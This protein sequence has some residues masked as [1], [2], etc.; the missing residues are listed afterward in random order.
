MG[1]FRQYGD[2]QKYKS[3]L[4]NGAM[5]AILL[6]LAVLTLFPIY[7]MVISSFGP[8]NEIGAASYTLFPKYVTLDSY[9]FF[10]GFSKSSFRWIVNS[11]IVAG[12]VTLSNVVFA[13]MA[14][15]AFAK[16]RFPGSKVLFFLL[17]FAMMVPYQVTQVPLYI[18]V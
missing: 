16:V 8:P 4:R 15:Y 10:F 2:D 1:L 12:V 14:G 5:A 18:L 17:L 7:Y 6:F 11:M 13:G 9:K 3:V